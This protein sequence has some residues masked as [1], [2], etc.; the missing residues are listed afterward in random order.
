MGD[1]SI[2]VGQEEGSVPVTVLRIQGD[3]DANTYKDL[4]DQATK[5]IE[6]G[7]DNILLDMAD[8]EYMGSA[9]F[10]AIHAMEIPIVMLPNGLT[11]R[12]LPARFETS[13]ANHH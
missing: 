13:V 9:G 10:R 1:L 11:Q 4:Q 7:A 8:V 12:I 2:L 5:I 6:G 3:V